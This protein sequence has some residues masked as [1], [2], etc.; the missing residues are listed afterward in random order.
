MVEDNFLE[1]ELGF[2]NDYQRSFGD[3]IYDTYSEEGTDFEPLGPPC[4]KG[5]S[6]D[7]PQPYV[8]ESFKDEE[9]D[10][11]VCL[12]VSSV[13]DDEIQRKEQQISDADLNQ[14]EP[15]LLHVPIFVQEQFDF[16]LKENFLPNHYHD[17]VE[18]RMTEVFKQ[19]DSKSFGSYH[20]MINTT[21]VPCPETQ[22]T[23]FINFFSKKYIKASF[24]LTRLHDWLHW[25]V[26]YLDLSCLT[27]H[28]ASWLHWL[29]EYVD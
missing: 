25:K 10:F 5:V 11:Q 3:P 2:D 16:V 6:H 4:F 20:F 22:S 27:N 12:L 1:V 23:I 7:N 18:L 28:L 15:L 13:Y 17:P 9:T 14:Q 24:W 8:C 19:A 29:F 26:D 21:E